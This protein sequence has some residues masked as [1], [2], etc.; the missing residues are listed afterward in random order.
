[1]CAEPTD[2]R[3]LGLA[4]QSHKLRALLTNLDRVEMTAEET[5]EMVR[6]LG[7]LL[8]LLDRP[9]DQEQA[10]GASLAT[11]LSQMVSILHGIEAQQTTLV[12]EM[13]TVATQC[14]SLE[15]TLA[16]IEALTAASEAR[17]TRMERMVGRMSHLLLAED[18]PLAAG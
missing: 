12:G 10:L 16:R 2:S 1:M 9:E 5:R 8:N 11:A 14:L 15:T 6:P 7:Q 18:D 17:L 3:D 4:D 13:A